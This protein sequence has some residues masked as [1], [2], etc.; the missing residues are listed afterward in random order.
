MVWYSRCGFLGLKFPTKE[1]APSKENFLLCHYMSTIFTSHNFL[2]P[3]LPLSLTYIYLHIRLTSILQRGSPNK[4]STYTYTTICIASHLSPYTHMEKRANP[5]LT[6]LCRVDAKCR[7][8]P[9]ASRSYRSIGLSLLHHNRC[10]Y[11]S[12]TITI[13]C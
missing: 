11:F 7:Q 1:M 12:C 10:Y 3:L 5:Y 6:T 13:H 9:F 8:V 4:A 2:K